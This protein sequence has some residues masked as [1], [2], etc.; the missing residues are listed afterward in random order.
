MPSGALTKCQAPCTHLTE[1]GGHRG[2][3]PR[4]GPSWDRELP[5]VPCGHVPP[6]P[7][8]WEVPSW[9]LLDLVRP[10]HHLL[11]NLTNKR[12][13]SGRVLAEKSEGIDSNPRLQRPR[14]PVRKLS[15]T[16]HS[17]WMAKP[18]RGGPRPPAPVVPLRPALC[19]HP[20]GRITLATLV[21]DSPGPRAAAPHP[22]LLWPGWPRGGSPGTR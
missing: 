2:A 9:S 18:R 10:Q 14:F 20:D 8:A 13:E 5:L 11:T 16:A 21:H 12:A 19:Q 15:A 17:S 1:P 3:R 22:S 6:G 4:P 7:E